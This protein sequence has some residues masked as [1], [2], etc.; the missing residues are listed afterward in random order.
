M[1]RF[2]PHTDDRA[3]DH[4]TAACH[5]FI[6]QSLPAVLDNPRR[7]SPCLD[8]PTSN[9]RGIESALWRGSFL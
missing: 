2:Q 5:C 3:L 9:G 7:S 4:G 1:R 8:P 6:I